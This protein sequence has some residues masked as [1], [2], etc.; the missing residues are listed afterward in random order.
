MKHLIKII[1][2]LYIGIQYPFWYI[3]NKR[4]SPAEREKEIER[5]QNRIA[6]LEQEKEEAEIK[7][8]RKQI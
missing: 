3:K 4:M 5:L 6:E 8:D 2:L 7:V 1:S